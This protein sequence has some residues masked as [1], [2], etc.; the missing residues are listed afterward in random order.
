MNDRH[1]LFIIVPTYFDLNKT[2][3]FINSCNLSLKNDFDIEFFIS[4]DS[5]DR[6][7][8]KYFKNSD[9]NVLC[10]DD[11][12]WG[13]GINLCL[14]KIY[15]T[16]IPQDSSII[17]ANNDILVNDTITNLINYSRKKMPLFIL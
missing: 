11:L 17:F 15:S 16:G 1:K 5:E 13:G 7:T 3:V 9:I 4:D 6:V 14:D 8:K 12:W 10:G 2:I